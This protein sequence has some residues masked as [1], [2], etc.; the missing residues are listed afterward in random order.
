M[1]LAFWALAATA[2]TALILLGYIRGWRVG[3]NAARTVWD[4]TKKS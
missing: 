3:W 1:D 2:A 4:K